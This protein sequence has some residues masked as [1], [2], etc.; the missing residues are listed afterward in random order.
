MLRIKYWYAIWI[1]NRIKNTLLNL[2][3]FKGM[4]K[5]AIRTLRYMIIDIDF[6]QTDIKERSNGSSLRD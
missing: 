2:S 6:I 4:S 1:L 5:Y 3:L